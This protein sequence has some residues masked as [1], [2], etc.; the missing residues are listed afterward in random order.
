[1]RN[2][3]QQL[4]ETTFYLESRGNKM[5]LSRVTDVWGT[6]WQMHTDNASHRAYRGLGIKEFSTLEDVEKN[7]KSWR[8]IAALVN[9]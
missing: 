2:V 4:G 8:G 3:I 6:H 1:M 7:Y 9:A 5:T